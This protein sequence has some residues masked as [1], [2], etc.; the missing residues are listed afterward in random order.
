MHDMAHRLGVRGV[1]DQAVSPVMKQSLSALSALSIVMDELWGT[2]RRRPL[3]SFMSQYVHCSSCLA[4]D[5]GSQTALGS[6]GA[7]PQSEDP[8]HLGN[9]VATSKRCY[10]KTRRAP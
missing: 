4:N 9:G 5:R 2:G 10:G 3:Q 7:G 6:S 1:R 8:Y